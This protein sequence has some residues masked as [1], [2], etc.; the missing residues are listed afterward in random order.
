MK[1]HAVVKE[2]EDAQSMVLLLPGRGQMP[3][4]IL[5]VYYAHSTLQ[6]IFVAIKPESEWYPLPRGA[7]DQT[8]AVFGISMLL[9]SFDRLIKKL[10]SKYNLTRKKIALVGFSAGAVVA[11]QTAIYADEPFAAVVS[12][13]GAILQPDSLP[14]A[15]HRTPFLLIHSKDDNCFSWEER[16]LPMKSALEKQGYNIECKEHEQN[17]HSVT[18]EDIEIAST[19][20]SNQ[21]SV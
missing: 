5:S 1:F 3:R 10:E 18:A 4:D 21:F 20:L 15:E 13:A 16:Y 7:N 9:P 6:S 12:H 14:V 2:I 19:F 11:I 17:G 8:E